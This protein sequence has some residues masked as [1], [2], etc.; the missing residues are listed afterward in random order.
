MQDWTV[1]LAGFSASL[2]VENL[3]I[4]GSAGQ[5]RSLFFRGTSSIITMA[6]PFP[7]APPLDVIDIYT[8]QQITIMP[9]SVSASSFAQARSERIGA[10]VTATSYKYL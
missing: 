8:D 1:R 5:F 4:E 6:T 9:L 7:H 2:G 10:P 3:S